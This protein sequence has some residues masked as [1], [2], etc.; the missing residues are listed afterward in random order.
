MIFMK[1]L[2][3]KKIYIFLFFIYLILQFKDTLSLLFFFDTGAADIQ[4]L[5]PLVIKKY[6]V[7]DS[8]KIE[9]LLFECS[10]Y[11]SFLLPIMITVLG[12]D[13]LSL[14]ENYLKYYIGRAEGYRYQLE[15]LRVKLSFIPITIFFMILLIIFST[16]FFSGQ[17]DAQFLSSFANR[18]FLN[19]IFSSLMS[20]IFFYLAMISIAILVNARLYFKLLDYCRNFMKGAIFYLAFIWLLSSVLYHVLP[21][22]FVPMNT[23][24]FLSY[25]VTIL[26]ILLPYSLY[27]LM[28]F[29]LERYT[30][31]I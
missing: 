8:L 12:Y 28:F 10:F 29:V 3:F 15:N 4:S 23:I 30:H 16:S 11:S 27:I 21:Y 20:Y 7:M 31:E 17:L 14:K 13:Y 2:R 22:Y 18:S 26:N 24:M 1:M 9:S 6:L 25:D 5:Q 19:P